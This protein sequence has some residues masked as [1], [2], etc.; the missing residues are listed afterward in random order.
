MAPGTSVPTTI[1][2]TS[3]TLPPLQLEAFYANA[4]RDCRCFRDISAT[5]PS[6]ASLSS[7]PSVP[8]LF[9]TVG[10]VTI[11]GRRSLWRHARSGWAASSRTASW[12]RASCHAKSR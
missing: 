5:F 7:P 1:A 9:D 8:L 4:R 2:V 6:L 11:I 10:T 3:V 12:A